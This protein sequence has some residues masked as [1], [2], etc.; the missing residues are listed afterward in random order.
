MKYSPTIMKSLVAQ[1]AENRCHNFPLLIDLMSS[2]FLNLHGKND[3][4]LNKTK[5]ESFA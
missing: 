2:I 1:S 3:T 5:Y 4:T